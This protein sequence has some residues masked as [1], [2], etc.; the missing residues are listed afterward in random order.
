V[1]VNREPRLKPSNFERLVRPLPSHA[2]THHWRFGGCGARST[3]VV[4]SGAR[5][6]AEQ[7][8]AMAAGEISGA[9]TSPTPGILELRGPRR[10][11]RP[12][13]GGG[14]HLFSRLELAPLRMSPLLESG[15]E[16][17]SGWLG[18]LMLGGCCFLGPNSFGRIGP[19]LLLGGSKPEFSAL[20]N[21]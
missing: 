9:K 3:I 12:W 21:T 10:R 17:E 19:H 11:P 14:A 18:F 15:S 7:S 2:Y 16:D 6:T 20:N 13:L 4:Y 8:V 5:A 1:F